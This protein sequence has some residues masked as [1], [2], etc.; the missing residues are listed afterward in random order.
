MRKTKYKWFWVWDFEKEERWLNSMAA[1]GWALVS[2]SYCRYEFESC[3][4][5]SCA[6]RLEML[7][8]MPS[9]AEG[10]QYIGFVE[11]TGAQY[12]GHVV[13]WAYFR[14]DVSKGAFNLYSD[15]DSRIRHVKRIQALLLPLAVCNICDLPLQVTNYIRNGYSGLLWCAAFVAAVTA[16]MGYGL[17]RVGAMRVALEK[18]RQLRE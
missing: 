8:A 16:M 6:I 3:E 5:G 13:R 10:L 9:S 2:V 7:D 4:P 11:E 1:Q 14:K 18:E 17:Y 15:L 12:V